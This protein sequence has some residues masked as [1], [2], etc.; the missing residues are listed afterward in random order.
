MEKVLEDTSS[1]QLQSAL[2]EQMRWEGGEKRTACAPATVWPFG[3]WW[4]LDL[5][6]G[7]DGAKFLF[8]IASSSASAQAVCRGA[9]RVSYDVVAS[10]V[11]DV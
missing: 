5:A 6:M 8:L 7:A 11:S 4:Q 2:L 3:V 10:K 1:F 9:L